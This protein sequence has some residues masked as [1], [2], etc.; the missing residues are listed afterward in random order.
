MYVHRFHKTKPHLLFVVNFGILPNE[1]K[2]YEGANEQPTYFCVAN[3]FR[4]SSSNF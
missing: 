2:T 1:D 3:M 4:H